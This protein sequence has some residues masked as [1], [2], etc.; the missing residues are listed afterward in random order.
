[1]NIAEFLGEVFV[2]SIILNVQT[3]YERHVGYGKVNAVVAHF[4]SLK[5]LY[6]NSCIGI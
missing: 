3:C 5:T 1:M 4:R 6:V 2:S